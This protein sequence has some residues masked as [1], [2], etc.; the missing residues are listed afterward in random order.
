[1]P[2]AHEVGNGIKSEDGTALAIFFRRALLRIAKTKPGSS[3]ENKKNSFEGI[4]L[5]KI[6]FLYGRK[7]FL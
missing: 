1:M 4:F 5:I 7:N 6:N 2:D 3:R